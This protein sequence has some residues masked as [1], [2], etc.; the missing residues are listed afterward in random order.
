VIGRAVLIVLVIIGVAAC[1][2]RPS[3]TSVATTATKAATTTE[4]ATTTTQSP[5]TTTTLSPAPVV[6][7]GSGD[8]VLDIRKPSGDPGEAVA[9]HAVYN[10]DASFAITPLDASLQNGAS[11]VNTIGHY[12]GVIALDFEQGSVTTKL[13]VQSSG[14]FTITLEP[15]ATRPR[16]SSTV[17]GHGDDVIIYTG[18][19]GTA[20]LTHD[21]KA[22]FVVDLDSATG[23][24]TLVNKTGAF[25]GQAA[26]DGA[27]VVVIRA[28]GNW[29]ISI[30]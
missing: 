25:R 20:T 22:N 18:S 23:Q 21:G 17:A 12:D 24:H 28:D 13:K 11:I 27:G 5:A 16:F 29:T 3:H 6:L 14:P 26:V 30:R 4:P 8:S 7:S 2:N 1:S 9:V 10:G 19:A 15:L